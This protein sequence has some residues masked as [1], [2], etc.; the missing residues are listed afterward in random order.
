M[1][2]FFAYLASAY[3]LIGLA[4]AAIFELVGGPTE[5]ETIASIVFLWPMYWMLA[6]I[7]AAAA[8]GAPR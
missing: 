1:R 7:F 2:V 4:T 3:L 5:I 8:A 6:V